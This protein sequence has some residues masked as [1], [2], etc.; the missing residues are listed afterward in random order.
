MRAARGPA[1]RQPT[2]VPPRHAF[3][4]HGSVLYCDADSLPLAT[5]RQLS[6]PGLQGAAELEVVRALQ[7]AGNVVNLHT[8]RQQNAPRTR[9]TLGWTHCVRTRGKS[10]RVC[11][12][13]RVSARCRQLQPRQCGRKQLKT[14]N[15]SAANCLSAVAH[16]LLDPKV[17]SGVWERLAPSSN[18]N[19]PTFTTAN[20]RMGFLK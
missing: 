13:V 10:A 6:G 1:G 5:T 20:C 8:S 16:H 2:E 18:L 11:A 19:Q 9:G 3:L 7:R 17:D 12:C 15:K 14:E 4:G